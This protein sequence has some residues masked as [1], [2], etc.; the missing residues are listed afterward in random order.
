[1]RD[2][3]NNPG[4]DKYIEDLFF[5]EEQQRR[6]ANDMQKNKDESM[7][8]ELKQE[9]RKEWTD[10][11][12]FIEAIRGRFKDLFK[13][14]KL[15]C[16]SCGNDT[17]TSDGGR[18]P[19]A[20]ERAQSVGIVER[21]K[22][23]SCSKITEFLRIT[24]PQTLWMLPDCRKGRCGEHT[25]VK[26]KCYFL[27]KQKMGTHIFFFFFWVYLMVSVFCCVGIVCLRSEKESTLVFFFSVFFLFQSSKNFHANMKPVIF[28]YAFIFF[29][30]TMF[31]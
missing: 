4:L 30:Q 24:S 5:S 6:I 25:D 9:L 3:K 17:F 7:S 26:C 21:H 27:I 11:E 2:I 13:W 1:M 8:N 29:T 20:Q 19:N 31:F 22:C 10:N 16:E 28:F 14:V 15:S 12:W 23:K 18:H